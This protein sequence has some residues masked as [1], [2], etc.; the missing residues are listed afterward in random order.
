MNPDEAAKNRKRDL[1]NLQNVC[2]IRKQ[3]SR[4]MEQFGNN[5]KEGGHSVSRSVEM[6][7][8]RHVWSTE[9]QINT[10]TT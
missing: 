2:V 6:G 10:E 1:E 5:R 8:K 9:A 4:M 3:T 7:L